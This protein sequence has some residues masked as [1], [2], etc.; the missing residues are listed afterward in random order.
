M[1][2]L[3]IAGAAP[4]TCSL[5]RRRIVAVQVPFFGGSVRSALRLPRSDIHGRPALSLT[6]GILVLV[7]VPVR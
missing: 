5:V 7:V 3:R 4:S 6:L 2:R 1:T